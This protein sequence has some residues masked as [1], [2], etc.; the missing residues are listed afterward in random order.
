MSL[1]ILLFYLMGIP[2]VITTDQGREF[3]NHLNEV[4]MET[5]G[6]DH[7]LTTPY[8]PQANR[9][10]ERLNKTL[11]NSEAK[12]AREER[13]TWDE[14]LAEIVY[15]YNTSVQVYL[16]YMLGSLSQILNHN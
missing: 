8:H 6:I 1:N 12:Y 15:A 9:L 11:M 7:Q 10:D 14:K 13:E 5:F 16:C 4:L 3:H 2:S